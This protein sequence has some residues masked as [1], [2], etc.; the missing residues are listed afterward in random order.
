MKP[1]FDAAVAE[2]KTPFEQ[3]KEAFEAYMKADEN[4]GTASDKQA[5]DIAEAAVFEHAIRFREITFAHPEVIPLLKPLE[6]KT[7]FHP[8]HDD[9]WGDLVKGQLAEIILFR[10]Y[11]DNVLG[12]DVDNSVFSNNL[13]LE[14][15]KLKNLLKR[16]FACKF[17]ESPKEF[18]QVV[19]KVAR[20][21]THTDDLQ[22]SPAAWRK[23][24]T[25][26]VAEQKPAAAPKPQNS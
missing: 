16:A 10:A 2:A 12:R 20:E 5:S 21:K 22:L 17:F 3:A 26:V 13:A 7:G 15:E 14:D 25:F 9:A 8:A 23:I 11:D 24:M 4:D 19:L 1:K 6:N 18:S